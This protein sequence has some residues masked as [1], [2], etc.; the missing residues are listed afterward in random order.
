MCLHVAVYMCSHKLNINIVYEFYMC[1]VYAENNTVSRKVNC[2]FVSCF[3][4][5]W[6]KSERERA[7]QP[8]STVSTRKFVSLLIGVYFIINGFSTLAHASATY[9]S[10]FFIQFLCKTSLNYATDMLYVNVTGVLLFAFVCVWRY[11]NSRI[12]KRVP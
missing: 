8:A 11:V 6:Q 10:F 9:R 1:C 7:N 4:R 5:E 3:R 2:I 12:N